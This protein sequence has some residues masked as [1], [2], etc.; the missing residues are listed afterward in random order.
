MNH[1]YIDATSLQERLKRKQ[2]KVGSNMR[3]AEGYNDA[4]LVFKSVIHSE[5]AAN[6]QIITHG[7]WT[8]LCS[9]EWCCTHCGEVIHTEG[10]WEFPAK[11]YCSNC[12]AKM[13]LNNPY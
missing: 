1:K 6:V 5:P 10:S 2:G 13:K 3:Y 7:K 12:G 8:H 9:G 11:N 4:L